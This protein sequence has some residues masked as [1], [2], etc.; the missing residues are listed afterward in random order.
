[1]QKQKETVSGRTA[2]ESDRIEEE[3]RKLVLTLELE[4]GLA[5][6]ET[7]LMKRY[8]W[9]RTPLREA[10][11]RLAQ[12]GLLNIIP[13]QGVVIAPL[14]VFDFVEVMDAMATVIGPSTLLACKRLSEEQLN[15]LESLVQESD[16][17][18]AGRNFVRVAELDYEFH[19]ILAEATGNRY[20]R[21]YLLH[22]HQVA[23]RFNLAAWMR[24]GGIQRSLNEHR[25]IVDTLRRRDPLESKTVMYEHIE[26]ARQR[27]LGT[28]P[29]GLVE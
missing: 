21:D 15:Q 2:R 17:A 1:M 29:Q 19:R 16:S 9:G 10:F 22:L 3:L 25:R 28:M 8:E 24:D 6:S 11:Q 26:N 4:P 23:R 20:L 14:S 12:Q 18:E 13:H 7:T 5:V 27:V